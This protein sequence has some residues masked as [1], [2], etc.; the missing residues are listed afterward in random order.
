MHGKPKL[1]CKFVKLRWFVLRLKNTRNYTQL[2]LRPAAPPP[3]PSST[4]SSAPQQPPNGPNMYVFLCLRPRILCFGASWDKKAC[5]SEQ[6]VYD[7]LYLLQFLRA[8]AGNFFPLALCG[9]LRAPPGA[10]VPGALRGAW[11]PPGGR[12]PLLFYHLCLIVKGVNN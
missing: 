3:L 10:R 4:S 2:N 12:L 9:A 5:A 8:A 7:F 6:T 11:S 1:L